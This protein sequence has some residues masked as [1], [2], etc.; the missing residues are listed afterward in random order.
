MPYLTKSQLLKVGFRSVGDNVK[1]SEHTAI[2]DADKISIGDNTRVDDF[3]ILSG[4]ISIGKY[5]HVTPMCLIAGGVPGVFIDDYSTLAYG[6]KVFSQSDDYSGETMA[7]SLI[8]KRYKREIFKAVSLGRHSI[9]GAGSIILPG[10]NIGE[11]VSVGAMSLVLE[12]TEDWMI[13]AG[14]PAKA[15]KPRSRRLLDLVRQFEGELNDPIQ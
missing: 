10:A 14:I 5:V 13:Y 6:V 7:N 3:C 9:V 2:Y 1:I 8:P 4:N 11:G 15:M 12:P